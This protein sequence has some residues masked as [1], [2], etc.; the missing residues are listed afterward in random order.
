MFE[1]EHQVNMS[2]KESKFRFIREVADKNQC[3]VA[4][5]ISRLISIMLRRSLGDLN[6]TQ[7]SQE[8]DKLIEGRK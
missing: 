6:S 2:L 5:V 3:S 1:R 4:T 7:F 8:L